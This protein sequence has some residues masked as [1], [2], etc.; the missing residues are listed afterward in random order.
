MPVLL[1]I[2]N[3]PVGVWLMTARVTIQIVALLT[4]DSKGIICYC[5][6]STVLATEQG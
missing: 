1:N 4:D 6:M 3:N 5:N 2:I